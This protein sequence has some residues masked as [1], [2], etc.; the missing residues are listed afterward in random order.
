MQGAPQGFNPSDSLIP[1]VQADIIG[2]QGGGGS[3]MSLGW[4]SEVK[5]IS[6]QNVGADEKLSAAVKVAVNI[7]VLTAKTGAAPV[8]P[9]T[10][11]TSSFSGAL[12]TAAPGNSL[13]VDATAHT[14]SSSSDALSTAAP[15][16][17]LVVDATAHTGSS[18]SDALST[19]A[20]PSAPIDRRKDLIL[21]YFSKQDD[22]LS[23]GRHALNN[24]L[25]NDYF[26]KSGPVITSLDTLPDPI[27]LQQLCDYI[28]KQEG[29]KDLVKCDPKENYEGSI[30]DFAL[31]IV[32]FPTEI[33]GD[34]PL[35]ATG[36][37]YTE[38]NDNFRGYIINLGDRNS[39]D[40][41]INHWVALRKSIHDNF[42][43]FDSLRDKSGPSY[44]SLREY[45]DMNHR[46]YKGFRTIIK[47]LRNDSAL[48]PSTVQERFKADV[49][50]EETANDTFKK[51]KTAT[52]ALINKINDKNM[53]KQLTEL[54]TKHSESIS[55]LNVFNSLL[56]NTTLKLNK[57]PHTT[58]IPTISKIPKNTL[59]LIIVYLKHFLKEPLTLYEK[60][61]YFYM[62]ATEAERKILDPYLDG[63]QQ[64]IMLSIINDNGLNEATV[65]SLIDSNTKDSPKKFIDLLIKESVPR[66]PSI[67]INSIDY[68]EPLKSAIA[69]N[70]NLQEVTKQRGLL[71]RPK[72]Y[73]IGDVITLANNDTE[74]D[75]RFEIKV[76]NNPES[77][78]VLNPYI[79]GK[80][81]N[82]NIIKEFNTLGSRESRSD[83]F[84]QQDAEETAAEKR[85][86]DTYDSIVAMKDGEEINIQ[87]T[88]EGSPPILTKI[89]S[90]EPRTYLGVI[91]TL[92]SD[93]T[94]I[95]DYM[96]P[97]VRVRDHKQTG[98]EWKEIVTL[99]SPIYSPA[100][101]QKGLLTPK[102]ATLPIIS[103]PSTPSPSGGLFGKTAKV[104]PLPPPVKNGGRRTLRKSKRV[105]L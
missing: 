86:H 12:S 62:K 58:E 66:P 78:V 104:S 77:H 4:L 33:I 64:D 73:Y 91:K 11:T 23:C 71:N 34:V 76:V 100:K 38:T 84:K 96:K 40:K 68:T 97:V 67:N 83:T 69:T 72:K 39:G 27:P 75:N 46:F 36:Y 8:G 54:I 16:N 21:S 15:G 101:K 95:Y 26:I 3:M 88:T 53:K 48:K 59:A 81:M 1:R 17:S 56:T 37:D 60:P 43:Y 7:P 28:S 5:N 65:N 61:L 25:G 103:S 87:N 24:L 90:I 89:A 50:I 99:R 57:S 35:N 44:G 49:K 80:K 2:V 55:Q 13:V 79:K 42:V 32:G 6:F 29:L 105:T 14:G 63:D 45:L 92:E 51:A 31:G 82:D 102:A 19:A 10:S 94:I 9:I 70:K 18:S 52:L 85:W 22:P 20:P 47:V 93:G 98:S 30:L 41:S 74:Y